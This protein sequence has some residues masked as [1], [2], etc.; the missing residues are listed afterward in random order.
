MRSLIR[1]VALCTAVFLLFPSCTIVREGEVG[2]K[3]T[4]GK[5]KEKPLDKGVAVFNPFITA[6]QKVSTQTENMEVEL[7]LPSKEGLNIRAEISILYSVDGTR[8]PE[9][10]RQIGTNYER[11][12][13]LPV[14]RS[15]VADVSARYFA[16]DMHT[17]QRSI[18]EGAIMEQMSKVLLDR[19]LIVENVLVKSIQLPANLARSIEEKLEAE[20]Q[21]LRMEFVLQQAR[22]EADQQRI[23]AEGTRDAQLIIAEGLTAEVLRFKSIE[24]F[25]ELSRSPNAKVIISNGEMP[26]MIEGNQK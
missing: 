24:A 21:A 26:V 10:L 7:N 20:Q 4:L 11:S 12:V 13:I 19:G 6:V 2:V 15:A 18:I 9:L 17:G 25:L 16:K 1:F 23:R 22:Q 14:F 8:A 3:R 5:Y